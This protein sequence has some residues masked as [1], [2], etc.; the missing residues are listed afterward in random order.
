MTKP[1]KVHFVGNLT[2]DPELRVT[3]TGQPLATFALAVNPRRFNAYTRQWE[4]GPPTFHHVTCWSSLAENV[5]ASLKKG[6]RVHVLGWPYEHSWE[7]P[8][9]DKRSRPTINAEDVA[10]SLKWARAEVTKNRPVSAATS[11]G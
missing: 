2:A 3:N 10:P 7:T 11:L 1:R 5:V 6:Y 9:G 4:V 8:E